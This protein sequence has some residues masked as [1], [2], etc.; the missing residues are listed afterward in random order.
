MSYEFREGPGG[1]AV[2]CPRCGMKRHVS[3][4][5]REWTGLR[6]CSQCW[7][8]KHPQLSVRG[9]RDRQQVPGGALPEPTDV[10]AED[11]VLNEDGT[12]VLNEDGSFLALDQTWST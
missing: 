4:M 5:R 6:V 11:L 3:D 8:P 1:I 10:F 7:D 9:V 2:I 12:Y